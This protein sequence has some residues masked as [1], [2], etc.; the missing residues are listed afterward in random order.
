MEENTVK[1]NLNNMEDLIKSLGSGYFVRVGIIGAQASKTH[2]DKNGK[3]N[4]T[5]ADI[6]T[7][8]EFGGTSKNGKEQPPRRSFLADS[9]KFVL[10]GN[11]QVK[12]T[13]K[14][15]AMKNIFEK[16]QPKTF[17]AEIGSEALKAVDEGF[18]TNGFGKWKPLA[19]LKTFAERYEKAIKGYHRTLRAMQKGRIPYDKAMLDAYLQ[20]AQNPHILYQTG[21]LKKSI[22]FKVMKQK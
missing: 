12:S 3:G 6:G 19:S 14:K 2:K 5:N 9:I 15:S 16:H 1:F 8:H 20:E 13:L 22:S 4:L 11:N 10:N 7:F 17:L 18:N 21:A